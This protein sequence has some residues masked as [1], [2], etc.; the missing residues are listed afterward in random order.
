[1]SSGGMVGAGVLLILIGIILVSGILAF[2]LQI[3][4][5][6]GIIAGVVVGVIGLVGMFKGNNK[7]SYY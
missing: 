3:I 7:K 1:M 4:G 5:W 6:I 2:L